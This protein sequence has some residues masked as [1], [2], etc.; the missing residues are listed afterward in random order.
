MHKFGLGSTLTLRKMHPCGSNEWKVIRYG[1]DVKIQ[2]LGCDRIV[3]IDRPTL[4]KRIKKVSNPE[5]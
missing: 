3:M 2:C 5:G 4:L 1:S